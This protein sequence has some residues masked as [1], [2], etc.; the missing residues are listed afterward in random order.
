MRRIGIAAIM[1]ALAAACQ[2]SG[3]PQPDDLAQCQTAQA[4]EARI[5]ACTAVAQNEALPAEQRS[6]GF[7]A[8]GDAYAEAGDVTA[9][10]RDYSAALQLDGENPAAMLG[11]AEILIESGQLDAA[12][13][14]LRRAIEQ[15]RSARASEMMGQVALRRS[16]YA[17]AIG[18]FDAA[19]QQDPRSAGALAGRARAK[20]LSGDADGAGSDYDAAIRADGALAEAR[21]GRCWLSLEQERELERARTDAEAAVA[22][23]PQLVEAQLCRGV[24]QLRGGEWANARASFEAA[25]AVE[26]GNP[27]ALFG[28]GVARR[29]SGDNAGRQDMNLARDFDRHVGQ[30]FDEM[31]VE[32]Y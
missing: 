23:D 29:R 10:L 24:L 30:R 31:G 9:A 15:T 18:F 21:A 19:I 27:T 22:A 26:P 20:Q 6:I 13:P 4:A 14:L 5:A 28:R 16:Q 2:P 8:R 7:S 25:L 3:P 32:T 11:R 17:E 1:C 12:E